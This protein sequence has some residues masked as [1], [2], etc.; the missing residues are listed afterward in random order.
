ML[1][2]AGLAPPT[3]AP[4][5]TESGLTERLGPVDPKVAYADIGELS[6]FGPG[7]QVEGREVRFV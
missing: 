3:I 7:D 4:K 2:E 6:H 5:V 1:G